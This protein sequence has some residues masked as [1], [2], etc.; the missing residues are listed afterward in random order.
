[1]MA[2]MMAAARPSRAPARQARLEWLAL[3]AVALA[4]ALAAAFVQWQAWAR[5]ADEPRLRADWRE[6]TLTLAA[7][8]ALAVALAAH[9]LR[10][11]QRRRAEIDAFAERGRHEREE[12]ARRLRTLTDNLPALIA[13]VDREHRYRFANAH[14][15]RVYALDP[16]TLPGRHV[17]EVI[18]AGAHAA[19]SDRMAAVLAGRAQ[20]FERRGLAADADAY[21]SIDFVPDIE[22]DGSIP[23]FYVMV[24]D[25][26]ALKRAEEKLARL[27]LFDALTGLP[28]RHQFNDRLA[29][30]LERSAAAQAPV[31]LM[32]LDVDH[33]KR[34]NDS[35]GHAAGDDVLK[36]FA[37]RLHDAV[38][39]PDGVAR[40][41]GDEFV[42]ILE[43]L[44]DAADAATVADKVVAAMRPAFT[45]NGQSVSTSASIGIAFVAQGAVAPREL[46]E[47]ADAALY[48]AKAAGRGVWAMRTLGVPA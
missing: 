13:Y 31:A 37:R 47:I 32:F 27:A 16:A 15:H 28:N 44:V 46:L 3:A 2:R 40:L 26:T 11:S 36:E 48:E 7:A 18:G 17:S 10:L 6:Q 20:H 35:L 8:I 41:A 4:V 1:M 5:M 29:G 22:S 21:V 43:G 23:G 19:L 42:A 45:A 34:I 30:A 33:F 12:A 14:Y 24:M 9:G 38:R 39:D 25:I